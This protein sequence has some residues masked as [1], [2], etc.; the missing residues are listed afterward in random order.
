MKNSLFIR[1][2]AEWMSAMWGEIRPYHI[3]AAQQQ[4]TRPHRLTTH[5]IIRKDFC[6]SPEVFPGIRGQINTWREKT[7]LKSESPNGWY[8]PH[9]SFSITV[10][11]WNVSLTTTQTHNMFTLPSLSSITSDL[12]EASWAS[13]PSMKLSFMDYQCS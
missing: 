5:W 9:F 2:R 13:L 11:V 12:A 8:N 3:P 4:R 1:R 7:N 10:F 6:Q